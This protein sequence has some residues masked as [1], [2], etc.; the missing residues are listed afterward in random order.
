MVLVISPLVSLMVDQVSNLQ[1]RG[2]SAGILSGNIGVD[3]KLVASENDVRGGRLR[4]L[5]SAP[6]A[7]VGTDKWKNMLL[8]SPISK[9]IVAVAV[10]EAHC[11]YK[12]YDACVTLT[13]IITV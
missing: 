6:E 3:K 9:Q 12:W 7:V 5:F 2:V 11:V 8:D 1:A 10:D 4:L 13:V